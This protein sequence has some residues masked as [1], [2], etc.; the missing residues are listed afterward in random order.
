MK[1]LCSE[2]EKVFDINF[3][4]SDVQVFQLLSGIQRL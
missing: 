3:N 4:D 2:I 1:L